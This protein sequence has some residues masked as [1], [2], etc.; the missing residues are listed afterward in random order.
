MKVAINGFGRIGRAAFKRIIEV[1]GL[2]PVAINDLATAENLV[3]LLKHDTV[4]GRYDR[5]VKLENGRVTVDGRSCAVLNEKNLEQLP[6]RSMGIDVV[7]EC[8][9]LHKRG[10]SEATC[11]GGGQA[12]HSIRA[13]KKR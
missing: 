4:Y 2:D 12:R 5:E 8:R 10:R 1:G 3:Y 13:G 9:G 6:W 11:R 7:L